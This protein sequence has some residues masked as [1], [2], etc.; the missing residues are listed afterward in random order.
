[1]HC[2]NDH[3]DKLYQQGCLSL[4]LLLHFRSRDTV[5][6]AINEAGLTLDTPTLELEEPTFSSTPIKVTG[7]E[8]TDTE[9]LFLL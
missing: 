1:M 5:Q 6:Q 8:L 4:T 7:A 3:L 2:K 9:G